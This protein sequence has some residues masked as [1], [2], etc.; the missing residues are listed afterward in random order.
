MTKLFGLE[1]INVKKAYF[2]FGVIVLIISVIDSL[3]RSESNIA[4]FF[5]PNMF[6]HI[7]FW[8]L[9]NLPNLLRRIGSEEEYQKIQ[10]YFK[11]FAY[12]MIIFNCMALVSMALNLVVSDFLQAL[13]FF[14]VFAVG[15]GAISLYQYSEKK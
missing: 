8:F 4:Y 7:A 10:R 14:P 3:S 1:K 5:V 9:S 12:F 2:I 13:E 11:A 6:Y 15:L